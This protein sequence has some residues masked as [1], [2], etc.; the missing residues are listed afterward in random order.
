M[1]VTAPYMHDGSLS[2]LE[3]VVDFYDTGGVPNEGLD[4]RI[5]PLGLT[6]E[7]KSDLVDFLNALSGSNLDALAA[8]ARLAPIGDRI[9]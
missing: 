7:Q 9:Q 6:P 4:P 5:R 8:D 1:A 2:T 3:E